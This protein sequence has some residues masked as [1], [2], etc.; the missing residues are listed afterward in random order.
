MKLTVRPIVILLVLALIMGCSVGS[1]SY[2]DLK[3]NKLK[4]E[5]SVSFQLHISEGVNGFVAQSLPVPNDKN[6]VAHLVRRITDEPDGK[7][8][9]LDVVIVRP[10]KQRYKNYPVADVLVKDD[11]SVDSIAR[12]Y[13]FHSQDK[14]VLVRPKERDD[15]K[16]GVQYDVI[17]LNVHTGKIKTIA[18]DA[19]PDVSPSFYAKGWMNQ[20]G[21]LYLN[22]YSDGRLWSVDT[23]NGEVRSIKGEFNNEWPLY[24]LTASPNGELFWHEKQDGFLLYDQNGEQLKELPHT[25][26]Y[27]SYPAFEWSPDSQYSALAFTLND[28]PGNILGGEDAYI[29]APEV[30][31]VYDRNGDWIWDVQAKSKEGFTNVDW[32]GWLSEEGEGVISWYRLDRTEEGAAPRKTDHHYAM[33]DVTTGRQTELKPASRLEDLKSPVPVVNRTAQLL[34]IDR[35]AG[36]YWSPTGVQANTSIT[37]LSKSDDPQLIWATRNHT[38]EQTTIT[39]YNPADQSTV[40]TLFKERLGDELQVIGDSMILDNQMN[41]RWIK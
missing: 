29:I 30:V 15:H 41:Y 4:F 12:A 35:E 32:S 1:N 24:L 34:L 39:R 21:Q 13:G 9:Q 3:I 26:G 20:E 7:R 16:E 10:D 17:S 25:L 28:N 40:T 22:S 23:A 5:D 6:L 11:Y 14:L 36:L 19:V 31:A 33:V 18:A 38:L 8:F 37:L 27:H 2:G